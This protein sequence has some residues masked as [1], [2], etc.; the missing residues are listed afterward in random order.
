MALSFNV[1]PSYLGQLP[2]FLLPKAL[3][4]EVV[5]GGLVQRA[6]RAVRV[7]SLW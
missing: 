6:G 1:N 7:L 4:S 3:H 5:T 2:G